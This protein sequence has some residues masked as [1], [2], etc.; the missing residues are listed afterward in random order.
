MEFESV[1]FDGNLRILNISIPGRL[2]CCNTITY[3]NNIAFV[4]PCFPHDVF[5]LDVHVLCVIP[6]VWDIV[7][8]DRKSV[9]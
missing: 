4:N 5:V 1:T 6:Y 3:A 9:V 8:A 2:R 7:L